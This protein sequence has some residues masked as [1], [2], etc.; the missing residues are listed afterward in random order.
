MHGCSSGYVLPV[1]A[2]VDSMGGVV[3][4]GVGIGL[5]TSPRRAAIEKA[6][7]E[8][9]QEYDVREERRRELEFLEKGGNPLDFKFGTTASVSVQSTSLTDQNPEQFVTSEAK[10]SFALTASPHG[11]SVDSSGRP[12]VPTVCEPNTAD[13]LLLF[14]GDHDLPEGERNS[15]RP[16]RRNNIAPSE[17]S[18][19]IDGTQNAKES[20]DSAIVRP[21]A[22]RNRSR[23]NREGA[24]SSAVDMAQNRSGQGSV[25][26]VRGG[27]RDAKSKICETNNR[28]DQSAPSISILKSASSNGDITPKVIASNKQLDTELDGERLLEAKIGLTKA[29]LHEIKSDVTPP[30]ISLDIQHNQPSQANVE[31]TPA[32]IISLESD[33]GE[34]EQLV[35]ASLECPPSVATTNTEQETT[36]IQLNGFS[37]LRRENNNTST[38]VQNSNAAVGAEGLDSQSSWTQ[39]SIGLDVHKDSDICTN[40]KNADVNGK[41][42]GNASDVDGTANPAGAEIVKDKI[43]TET[44]NDGDVINDGHSSICLKKSDSAAVKIDK[45]TH[46]NLSEIPNEV[47]VSDTDELKHSD[48]MLSEADGKV[49]ESL[50]DNSGLQKENSTVI[51]EVPLDISMHE[52]PGTA[53]SEMNSTVATDPQTT[54]VN[55]LKVPDKAH[56]DSILEEARII[57]AKRKRI[58][59]LSVRSMPLENRRKTHWDFVLEEMAWLA[60]DFA[61]ERIWKIATAAQICHRAAFASQLRVKKQQQRWRLKEVAHALAKTVMLFWQSAEAILKCDNTSVF[62]DKCEYKVVKEV[63]KEKKEETDIVMEELKEL[64]VQCPGK[65]VTLALQGYAVRFLKYNS[66]CGLTQ[67][68]EAPATPDRISDLG[69]QDMCWEDHL[70]E[71]SLFYTVPS[72]AMEIY[73]KSIEAHLVQFE[74]T[75]SSMQEEVETSMYDAVSDYGFQENAYAEDEGETSTYYLPGAGDGIKSSKPTQK[76]KKNAVLFTRTY[77]PGADFAY[78]QN[79]SATQQSMLMGKRPSSLNVGSIPTKRM[80]T[81]TRQRVI[82]PFGA[83]PIA[84]VQVQMK[85]DASSGDTNSLQDD[86]SSLLGGSQFQKSMEVESASEYDKLL[87]YDCAETSIK[88]KKKKK[89]KHLVST[90]DQG[91]QLESTML[92]QREP[93][94]KRLGSNHFESNGTSDLYMQH[95]AKKPK[96]LKQPLENTF[97]NITT[98]TGSIPSPVASQNNI[99]NA[100]KIMK[101]IGGTGRDRGRKAKLLKMSMG[102]PGSGSPWSLFEDQ[103]LVVLVHDMG[104]NWELISDAINSTLHFKCIF[105]KPNECKERHKILMDKGS[106]DGADSAEDSGSSQPYPSTLPGIPKGSARQLFQRLKEP[107]EDETLKSHFD[108]IIKIGQKLHYRRTQNENQDLKQIAPVH[109][110]HVIALTPICPNNLNGGVLTPLDLCDTT[111]SNQDVLPLGCQSSHSS[112]LAIPNQG[113]VASLLPSSGVNS[114]LQGSSGVVLGTNLSS[115]SVSLNSTARDGRYSN[116]PRASSLPVEEQQRIQQYNNALA[117]RNIQQSSLPVPGALSGGDRGVRMLSG[118][119]AMGMMCGMNRSMPISRPGYQGMTSPSLLNSGSMLSSSMVGMPSPVNMHSGASSGQGNSMVRPHMIRPGHNP[120]HQRQMMVPELQMQ[121]AGNSQGITAFNGLN[122]AFS[123]QTNP[124]SVPSYP[125]HPQQQHQVSPQQ[126]HGH[127][128]PHHPPNH[129][130]SSQQQAYAIR[131]A[132]ERHMQQRYMHQQQQ[133]QQQFAASN[134]LMSHVQSQAHLPV[135]TTL[136]NSS[137]HQAQNPSQPVS[138]SPLTPSSPMTTIPAQHQQKHHLPPHGLSRN[139]GASGLTNQMGKQRQ[140]QQQQQHLQQA[141][142]HHPQQRQHVQSQQQAKLLKGV[143]RGLVQNHSVD[144]SHLNGL[145]IPPGSQSLEKGDQMMQMMQGQNVYS[146]SGLNAMQPPKTMVPQSSNHQ[147]L[148]VSSALPS[149]KQLHQMPSHSDNSTQGQV[150]PVS[151]GHALSSSQQGP[152]AV[153]GSNH[154]QQP[155]SQS[156]PKPQPQPQPHQKQVNQTQPNPHRIIQQN[157]QV[158]PELPGK[159]QND[160]AQAD[161]Q[162]VNNSSQVGAS[163]AKPQSCTD[164]TAAVP[165][166]SAI[167][168]QWKSS[169]PVFDSNLPNSTIQAGS[170]GSPS[171]SHSLGNE[172][173]PPTSQGLGPRQLSGSLSSH[174]HNVGTQWQQAQQQPPPSQPVQQSPTLSAA[175]QQY[176]QQEQ[177][178]QQPEQKSPQNQLPLQQ[179]PQQQIQHLQGQG[180]LYLR[181]ANSKAE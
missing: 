181:P 157:R 40:T 143:G 66:A 14:D 15:V 155:Q 2:E 13:N 137:Q 68:A 83:T 74:K 78:G 71:E 81:A 96:I 150:P 163:M 42:V 33:I 93:S 101:L 103:A 62:S 5:K 99:S 98:M 21:Y 77:E 112:G 169:E 35:S 153:M 52:L 55:S 167:G 149:T 136:Q 164:S 124:P 47:K 135:S 107:M 154:Q 141:G 59:E 145:S 26:P 168:T 160:L 76:K 176:M 113:A 75:G 127:S 86:Q 12:G 37:D 49:S 178:Q 70:T 100:N 65:D 121:V 58:A 90:Y 144:P 179:Q 117:G 80:R 111:S 19:Q 31:Q 132:K 110:S 147:K 88:P 20:E 23:S 128:S 162:P 172:P 53:L 10:G 51:C 1:N 69:I 61:Q 43:V 166:S 22:R 139:P 64:E 174:G 158:N 9:R 84:N 116:S 72:G 45:D 3:D 114:S 104:P 175:S 148:L 89:A 38:E 4:G 105:R 54:S 25:L 159:S 36:M 50:N 95:N 152:A 118:G 6:Q 24:R 46:G 56:E 120:E 8:L 129:A 7:V 122:P 171:L 138:L 87:P 16:N 173:T 60:N 140:R 126:S 108:K 30:K 94:K 44:V 109:S 134:A 106:G 92:E 17:Q 79:N 85:T 39:N 91:W 34:R 180:S 18:S 63:S 27:L 146:G 11:D 67:K 125:G 57:E 82:S 97:D 32:D 142:R 165:V 29:C 133:Q 73:R 28:K 161:Q 151:S 102:Q 119:N 156:Q 41:S 130:A 123:N 48:T 170:I 131:L 115:P 177:Q